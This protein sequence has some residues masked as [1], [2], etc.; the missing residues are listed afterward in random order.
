M[1]HPQTDMFGTTIDEIDSYYVLPNGEIVHPVNV[2]E[3][4]V[5]V[6]KAELVRTDE[7]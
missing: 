1:N 3:Y 2:D 7:G 6:L 4:F 5:Q